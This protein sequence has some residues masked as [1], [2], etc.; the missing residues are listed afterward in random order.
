[1]PFVATRV[2]PID[3]IESP[4]FHSTPSVDDQIPENALP[5]KADGVATNPQAGSYAIKYDAAN[6]PVV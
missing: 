4:K 1:M 2:L 6:L 5:P 3:T